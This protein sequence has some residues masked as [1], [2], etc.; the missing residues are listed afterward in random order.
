M[1]TASTS[2]YTSVSAP[3]APPIVR[4][5]LFFIYLMISTSVRFARGGFLTSNTPPRPK[6]ISSVI[7]VL[8]SGLLLLLL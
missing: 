2:V 3:S 6:G 7:G 5:F 8:H 1:L 4:L